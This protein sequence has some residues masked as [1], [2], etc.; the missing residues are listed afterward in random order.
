[1][2]SQ[3]LDVSIEL[4]VGLARYVLLTIRIGRQVIIYRKL[5]NKLF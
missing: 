2:Q 4:F 3:S 1:M 5:S